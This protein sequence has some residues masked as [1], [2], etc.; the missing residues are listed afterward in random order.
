MYIA[1]TWL[2]TIFGKFYK[3]SNSN[4]LKDMIHGVRIF[5]KPLLENCCSFLTN[6]ILGFFWPNLINHQVQ[7]IDLYELASKIQNSTTRPITPPSYLKK[8]VVSPMTA[9]LAFSFPTRTIDWGR[10]RTSRRS[11]VLR[12]VGNCSCCCL[13]WGCWG[14]F[15]SFL[16]NSLGCWGCCRRQCC[17]RRCG[18]ARADLCR[19]ASDMQAF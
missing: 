10:C 9:M 15:F 17:R 4:I 6:I 1:K 3:D 5:V 13:F 16:L 2:N 11:H 8:Y 12:L 18:R 19:V 14:C 7:E